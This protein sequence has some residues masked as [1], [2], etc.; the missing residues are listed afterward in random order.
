MQVEVAAAFLSEVDILRRS[1]DEELLAAAIA[2]GDLSTIASK[3]N[4]GRLGALLAFSAA[5]EEAVVRTSTLSGV[6]AADILTEVLGLE[7]RFNAVDPNVV[8]YA[9]AQIADL[10]ADIDKGQIE[11]IRTIIS[12]GYKQGLTTMQQSRAIREAIGLRPGH[13]DA[14]LRFAQEL[15]DGKAAAATRRRLSAVDKAMIRKRIADGTVDEAFIAEMQDRYTFSLL[16]RRA[17]D[18]AR[19]ETAKAANEGKRISWRQARDEGLL[20]EGVRR[21]VIVTPDERLRDTHAAVP[22]MNP[23]GV[24][25]DEPFDTPWGPQMGPPW[26]ADP[27][28]CRCDDALVFPSGGVL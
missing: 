9:R 4:I 23:D 25:L 15:R 13:A 14:P 27:Y 22:E 11:F 5:F 6:A 28:N 3:A 24:G 17:Q 2:S 19:T 21:I 16:N 12:T 1:I 8:L 20:P 7:V 26:P 10:I 18:I